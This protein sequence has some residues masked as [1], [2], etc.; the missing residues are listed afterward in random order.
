MKSWSSVMNRIVSL[1]PSSSM[2]FK[3]KQRLSLESSP[4]NTAPAIALAANMAKSDDILV[5][6]PADHAIKKSRIDLCAS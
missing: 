6:L 5:V 3:Q 2:K 1:L 4:R